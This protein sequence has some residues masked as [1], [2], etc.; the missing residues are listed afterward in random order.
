M[1]PEEQHALL[2][3]WQEYEAMIERILP[4]F[5]ARG[6]RDLG[7]DLDHM[8][9]CRS[10]VEEVLDKYPEAPELIRYRANLS[11]LDA[12]LLLRRNDVLERL[13]GEHLVRHRQRN[14]IPHSHWWWYLDEFDREPRPGSGP[15]RSTRRHEPGV[16]AGQS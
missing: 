16:L 1:M 11:G 7:D 13:T 8:L 4:T 6:L 9:I 10:E 12:E 14:G 15:E 3:A 2:T 5:A